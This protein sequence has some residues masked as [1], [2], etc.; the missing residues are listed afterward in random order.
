MI[1]KA[2][3][4]VTVVV[5]L[6][7][8]VLGCVAEP[9]P[10]PRDPALRVE[11][12]TYGGDPGGL[13]YSPAAQLTSDNVANLTPAWTWGVS[14]PHRRRTDAGERVGA[15]TF[16]V[17]PLMVADT[18]YL[19]TPFAGAVALDAISG[20]EIWSY[21]SGSWR[22][23]HPGGR[24]GFIHRGVALWTGDGERRVFLQSRW[25]LIA[26]DAA[27]G[28]A[29]PGFGEAGEVD[30]SRGLRWPVNPIHLTSTSPPV[31]FRDI[32]ITGSSI[33]DQLVHAQDPP[34][35]VQ[36]FDA[37]TGRRLWRWD[38]MPGEGQPGSESWDSAG[39][40]TSG[41][42]NVWS[43][44]TVDTARGL[45]YLPV[46]TASNDWY[47]G[48]RPGDNLFGESLVCLDAL[49][50]EL[51]W[52]FQ[53]IRHGLWDYDPAAPPNLV[54]IDWNGVPRDIVTVPGKTGFLYAFDRVSGEPLWPVED[55]P[56]PASDVPGE[57][58]AATQPFPTWPLPFAKQGFSEDDLVDFTPALRQ[59]ALE[60]VREF[61]DG[62][63][64]TPPSLE[65]T[66]VM[67][68]WI[69]GAG[70]GGGSVDPEHGIIYIKATERPSLARLVAP[71]EDDSLV[72][73]RYTLDFTVDPSLTLSLA[74][75]RGRSFWPPF[76][77]R[78]TSVPLNK[79]P[80][81][82]LT[83]IHLGTGEHLWQVPLGDT[84]ELHQHPTLQALALP[85]LG[86][87]GPPGGVVTAGGLIFITGGDETLYAINTA[88]GS[89]AG[90]WELGEQAASNPMTYQTAEGRQLVVVAV[91]GGRTA[92]LQAFALP[93][94]QPE[95]GR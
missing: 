40:A 91:G 81:G 50:G 9:L 19:S 14:E 70:W 11:W 69:G 92:R 75:P 57:Q 89:V 80:Y 71:P 12:P 2:A 52:H 60:K 28:S 67:P 59:M 5:V 84:P 77:R 54:T 72:D 68:G 47:G 64:F 18:L 23:P 94:T 45:L 8:L 1:I 29:V 95:G 78:E 51:V 33:S 55:R 56:V 86:R 24:P 26:L 53:M 44:M 16:Q 63:I 3:R 13:K 74:L 37:R 87:A 79:P 20:R 6:V 34:G 32:I 90:R 85:P 4:R 38:P 93:R 21:Q 31:V 49:T 27:T 58:A 61:R 42:M 76:R 83:A 25:K 88:D 82:T 35:D 66:L 65:G 22:W 46:S 73:A 41:H 10:L 7:G 43:A 30:L 62:P 48:R 15:G 36:A 17:T 39:R